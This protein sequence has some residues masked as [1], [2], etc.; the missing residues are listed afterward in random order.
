MTDTHAAPVPPDV[1]RLLL[2]VPEPCGVDWTGHWLRLEAPTGDGVL[3]DD[4]ANREVPYQ[5]LPDGQI[6][7]RVDLP[8]HG[9]L[10]LAWQA[11][12]PATLAPGVTVA[13]DADDLRLTNA[14]LVLHLAT[15]FAAG[16]G[17][18]GPLR[19]V[20]LPDGTTL[21]HGTFQGPVTGGCGRLVYAGPL[22]AEYE[23]V[24]ALAEGGDYR[25][26]ITLYADEPFALVREAM[27]GGEGA[28]MRLAV[29]GFTPSRLVQHGL[30]GHPAAIEDAATYLAPYGVVPHNVASLGAQSIFGQIG[31]PWLALADERDALGIVVHDGGGWRYP[32]DN[33]LHLRREHGSLIL[34]GDAEHGTRGWLLVAGPAEAW[35]PAAGQSADALA[36]LKARISDLPLDAVR[37]W[38]LDL[39]DPQPEPSLWTDAAGVQAARERLQGPAWDGLLASIDRVTLE[40][41][42]YAEE[43]SRCFALCGTTDSFPDGLRWLQRGEDRYARQLVTAIRDW[44]TDTAARFG[45]QG[46]LGAGLDV[47]HLRTLKHILYWYDLLRGTGVMTA[48]EARQLRRALLFCTYCTLDPNYFDWES[49][50][51]PGW[52][53]HSLRRFLLEEDYSD[54]IG[55]QN[56]HGDL[57][58]FIGA[59]GLAFPNHP[60]AAAWVDHAEAMAIAN[61]ECFIAPDGTYVESDNYYQ[62]FHGLLYYLGVAL[63]RAG[64]SAVLHHPR[65]LA[66]LEYWVR[67]QTPLLRAVGNPQITWYGVYTADPAHRP[68]AQMPPIG[69]A[70]IN[71]GGQALPTFLH[72]AANTLAATHPELAGW[73]EWTWQRAGR[74]LVQYNFVV[75]EIVTQRE[76]GPA[77]VAYPLRSTE[78]EGHGVFCRAGVDGPRETALFVRAGRATSHMHF[79]A[80]SLLL[81]HAGVPLVVDPG[82]MYDELTPA[83]C[84]G[85]A[86]HR[87]AT[88]TFGEGWNGYWGMEHQP[89]P[90]A[91]VFG[92]DF[93]YVLCDLSQNNVRDS[94]VWRKL[95]RIVS[96]EHYRQ[97]LCAKRG[98][99]VIRDR[100]ARSVYPATWHLPVLATG[101]TVRGNQV[102]FNGRYGVDL[103]LTLLEPAAPCFRSEAVSIIRQLNVRQHP[104]RGFLAVLQPLAP[105]A[106][107]FRVTPC[108]DGVIVAGADWEERVLLDPLPGRGSA[109][110]WHRPTGAPNHLGNEALPARCAVIRQGET[111]IIDGIRGR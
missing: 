22:A 9:R 37:R 1:N 77:P 49:A 92:D 94:G 7:C 101:E 83:R 28:A 97:V 102:H 74:P 104:E 33:T 26:T 36:R 86:S 106:E 103:L 109:G 6:L 105:G 12:T 43:E 62:H 20:C 27:T 46:L 60:Q 61:L 98:Y 70:G 55:C 15:T 78:L 107:P 35:V 72:H 29:D 100:I 91:V 58:T 80:G 32:G 81:W 13:E 67:A 85:G 21:A 66:G 110:E 52:S 99:V 63:A 76:E 111:V 34:Q 2:T 69:D 39:D 51:A 17:V 84:Y 45:R 59:M 44:A 57:F 8:A 108:R 96:I 75:Q 31:T 68:L 82:Y 65:M 87:H 95:R 5:R 41:R 40:N 88:V 53:A 42:V 23:A 56:F 10:A 90:L 79:D 18:A 19:N 71:W 93:D 14:H 24:L 25:M 64:R 11:G 54:T 47:V 3:W 48:E 16:E 50:Y 89:D 30:P 38:T 4:N 73:L